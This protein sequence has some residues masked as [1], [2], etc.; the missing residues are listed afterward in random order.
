MGAFSSD[1]R[2]GMRMLRKNPAT[3]AGFTVL[4]VTVALLACCFPARRASK[5]D[6][7]AVLRYE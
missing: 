6:P 3:Y 2:F 4:L 1:L 5:V 7:M